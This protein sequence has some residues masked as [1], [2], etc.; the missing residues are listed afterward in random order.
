ME[1]PRAA[2][3]KTRKNLPLQRPEK[4]LGG[5]DKIHIHQFFLKVVDRDRKAS[6]K[7]KTEATK[8]KKA[9]ATKKKTKKKEEEKKDE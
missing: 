3:N 9:E 2:R 1:L 4:K 7:I 5:G 6:Q 8:K